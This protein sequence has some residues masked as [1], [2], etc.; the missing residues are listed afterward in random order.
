VPDLATL[1]KPNPRIRELRPGEPDP[2]GRSVVY[3]MQR[4]QRGVDNLA[5]NHAIKLGN[6]LKLPVLAVFGLTPDYPDGQ[7]R[8]YRFLVEGLVDTQRDMEGKG[9]PLVVRIGTP[10]DVAA[11]VATEAKAAIVVGDENPVK[12]GQIWRNA[13]GTA[14]KVPIRLVDADVVVPTSLFPKEEFAARTIRPKIH[15]VWDEYLKPM[16]NPKASIAWEEESIPPGEV[17]DPDALMEKLKV[18]GVGEV[19]GYLGG[20]VEAI[21]RLKR[22]LKERLPVYATER[23]EPTPYNTT[24]L[25]AHLHFGQ[26]SPLTIA[27]AVMDSEAPQ[28]CI[29]SL[30]EELI[31]R[32]E[33]SINY[34][35][36]NPDYDKLTGCPA[37][38]LKTLA[39]HAD[40]PRPVLYPRERLEAGETGDPLWNA[41]QKE[42]LLTGRMHNYLRMYWGKKLL[43]WSPDAETAFNLTLEMNN[44]YFMDGRNPNGFTGV[45]WAIGGKHDRPWGERPIFGTIRFMSYESTR[46]KFDSKGY[47]EWVRRLEKEGR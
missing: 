6:A 34:V 8:H 1:L 19:A 33:L 38:G 31:V 39:K 16:T 42:M 5:L 12:V 4:A 25:S 29:D 14:L 13:L 47:I 46:K 3:W 2:E 24:E 20:T 35:T 36:H 10:N 7:R 28:E 9:V 30:L 43:E 37:W 45:A 21:R 15:R 41:A 22:F 32:R 17:I 26:I 40:D 11:Q 44:K 18:G 27:L 23:N